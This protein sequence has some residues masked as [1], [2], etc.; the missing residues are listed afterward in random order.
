MRIKVDEN[1]G[2]RGIELLRERGH[3]VTTVRDQGLAGAPDA[4]VFR[5]CKAEDRTLVTLD[6]DFGHVLRFPPDDSPGI[7][8]LDP[9]DPVSLNLLVRCL[10]EFLAVAETRP[11]RGELWIFEPGRV[12]MHSDRNNGD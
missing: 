11:V 6:R 7:V 1:I 4:T 8:V 10:R 5:V 12:R 3:D 9:G 2:R